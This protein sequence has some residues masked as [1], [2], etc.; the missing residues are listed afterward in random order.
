[1][2]FVIFCLTMIFVYWRPLNLPMWVF[3]TLGALAAFFAGVI[4][5]ENI[6]RVW[7]MV[8][9][10]TFTLVGLILLTLALEKIGFFAFLATHIVGFLKKTT[11]TKSQNNMQNTDISTFRFYVFLIL[12]SAFLS[13]FFAN[14]GAILILTPLIL[15]LFSTTK[16]QNNAS[17]FTPL[18]VSLLIVSFMSDFASN[19]FVISNLT[20]IITAHFF[21]LDS[22]R[23]SLIMLLPQAFIIIGALLFWHI[24]KIFL[25]QKLTFSPIESNISRTSI[26]FCCCVMLVLL[27]GIFYARTLHLPLCTFTLSCAFATVVYGK[28]LGKISFFTSLKSA[29]FGIVIFSLGLFIVVFGL[30]NGGILN[31]LANALPHF[32]TLSQ[33]W[34]ILT[35]G[36]ASG[37][38]SSMINNLPMVL[39]GNLTLNDLGVFLDAKESL[40]FA[41]LLGCNV[42]TKLTPIGSLATLLW[43]E[44]LKNHNINISFLRYMLIASCVSLPLLLMGLMGL[45]IGTFALG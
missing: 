19:T 4:S 31:L 26:I 5:I 43:L 7:E 17:F 1:M 22:A 12:F 11:R 20:N 3:S 38:G 35:L 32:A 15:T 8:S 6:S 37:I 13:A 41:H 40:I 10:S 23:F 42:G 24:V 25:P 45:M 28:F 18:V 2:A 33:Q 44:S 9:D 29:P 16:P 34:Q 36:I 14:D 21:N 39:L 27:F 30:K